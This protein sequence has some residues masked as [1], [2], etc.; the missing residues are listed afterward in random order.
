MAFPSA[1][2]GDVSF[3]EDDPARC[4]A[5][6]GSP[7][8][9]IWNARAAAEGAGTRPPPLSAGTRYASLVDVRVTEMERQARNYEGGRGAAGLALLLARRDAEATARDIVRSPG[10]ESYEYALVGAVVPSCQGVAM[11]PEDGRAIF[12]ALY[13]QLRTKPSGSFA[14]VLVERAAERDPSLRALYVSATSGSDCRELQRRSPARLPA[15][16]LGSRAL[17]ILLATCAR[18]HEHGAAPAL[19][20][21]DPNSA[22]RILP[23]LDRNAGPRQMPLGTTLTDDEHQALETYFRALAVGAVPQ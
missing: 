16:S 20:L 17:P 6:H 10:F 23:R 7:P 18:C 13:P 14:T 3:S 2:T 22:A 11:V 12:E 19:R 5:C 9:P 15:S 21:D 4:Q 8:R 1:A